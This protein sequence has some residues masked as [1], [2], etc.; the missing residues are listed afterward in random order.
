MESK[1]SG[2]NCVTTWPFSQGDKIERQT[3]QSSQYSETE[4]LPVEMTLQ[5]TAQANYICVVKNDSDHEIS[6]EAIKVMRNTTEL[7]STKR[8][9]T[10]DWTVAPHSGKQISWAPLPD[11]A[12]TLKVIETTLAQS[13]VIPIEFVFVCRIKG[14]LRLVS[15]SKLVATSLGPDA[16]IMRF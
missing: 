8:Q 12:R 4:Y 14:R 7:C 11:P 5:Q 13:N 2:K 9:T 3:T 6:I 15:F 1:R 10:D 16:T